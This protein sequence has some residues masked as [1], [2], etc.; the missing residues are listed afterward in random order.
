MQSPLQP[1]LPP[2]PEPPKSE[3]ELTGTLVQ[4]TA[5][6][7]PEEPEKKLIQPPATTYEPLTHVTS[8]KPSGAVEGSL[9][10]VYPYLRPADAASLWLSLDRQG[11]RMTALAALNREG[12]RLTGDELE[13]FIDS[14]TSEAVL[15]TAYSPAGAVDGGSGSANNQS[16]QTQADTAKRASTIV[17]LVTLGAGIGLA[18]LLARGRESTLVRSNPHCSVIDPEVD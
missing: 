12:I 15:T 17:S 4:K 8:V 3:S 6:V 18:Y 5:E 14:V 13:S 7:K 11:Q 1:P 10:F 2:P 9:V 16:V